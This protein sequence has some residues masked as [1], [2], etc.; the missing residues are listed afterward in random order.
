[1]P[2]QSISFTPP[3]DDWLKAQVDSEEYTSKSDVVNDL[4]R[5]AREIETIR[6]RLIQA[7]QSG[8]TQQDRAEILAEIKDEMRRN[9]SL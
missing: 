4:I 3:N 1:M 6:A 7:E 2:R 9:G 5:K 8:F